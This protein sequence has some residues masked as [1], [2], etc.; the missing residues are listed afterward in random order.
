MGTVYLAQD[1][2]L[3]HQVSLK[4][5]HPEVA[6]TPPHWNASRREAPRHRPVGTIPTSV[7]SMTL[8]SAR[9]STTWAM[10]LRRRR[11]AVRAHRLRRRRPEGRDRRSRAHI[12][13]PSRSARHGIIH[14]DLKPA[15][16]MI[17]ADGQPVV[18]DFG[19]ARRVETSRSPPDP[20]GRHPGHARLHA[21]GTGRRRHRRHRPPADVYSLGVILYELLTGRQP[22]RGTTTAVLVSVMRDD[23][24]RPSALRPEVDSFLEAVCLRAMAKDPSHAMAAWPTSLPPWPTVAAFARARGRDRSRV[25]QNAGTR[26]PAFWRT[27]L[28]A[29]SHSRGPESGRGGPQGTAHLG[30]GK[31]TRQPPFAAAGR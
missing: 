20:R 31:G 21:A 15:N 4:V 2:A 13:R 19:L 30:L 1:P 7:R 6:A 12:A 24:P 26:K 22:F 9:A 5:P 14:R 18:M 28:R 17:E 27:R 3:G 11:T 10:D 8:A 23:P 16:V 29:G 25:R